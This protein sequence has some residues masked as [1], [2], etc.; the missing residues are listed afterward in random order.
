MDAFTFELV[1]RAQLE[2]IGFP[3]GL[4]SRLFTKFTSKHP[5]NLE[6]TFELSPSGKDHQSTSGRI[7]KCRRSLGA[8]SDVF[9][10]Q[11]IWESDGGSG[12]RKALL[13][14]HN[15]LVRIENLLGIVQRRERGDGKKEREEMMEVICQQTNKSKSIAR[16][17]LAESGYDLIAAIFLAQKMTEGDD[18]ISKNKDE[19]P[20]LTMEEFRRGFDGL[21]SGRAQ[22]KLSD[23][24]I[25]AM[26]KDWK[27]KK[28]RETNTE[29]DNW[30]LC[31]GY[32]W[33]LEEDGIITV[34]IPLP[35]NTQK[36]DIV[37][38][39]TSRR[40]KFG[41]RGIKQ[42]VI[43]GEFCGRIVPDD[44]YWTIDG[45]SVSVSVQ[46]SVECERWRELIAGEVQREEKDDEREI[47]L[48]VDNIMER[49]WRVNQ[50]YTAV[51]QEGTYIPTPSPYNYYY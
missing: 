40:W 3:P 10:L 51:T 12:A 4:I 16:K 30:V 42:S 7:L 34:I 39:I 15:L 37:S 45:D 23:S 6:K 35:P 13:N 2:A 5:E 11:H 36:K 44:C 48:R 46:R 14:D 49:M 8:L 27:I 9:I 41:F 32:K 50:T 47:M 38:D 29:P 31:E 26:Y 1:H 17:A 25:E 19:K 21:C 33:K 28:Q 18:D 20:S 24:D 43:D 22:D